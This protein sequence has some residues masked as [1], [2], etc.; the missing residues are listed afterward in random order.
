MKNLLKKLFSNSKDKKEAAVGRSTEEFASFE[1]ALRN[2][3]HLALKDQ[4]VQT[5]TALTRGQVVVNPDE[6]SKFQGI[7][8]AAY[9]KALKGEKVHVISLNEVVAK[10]R[11]EEIEG[12]INALN[13]TA[14]V[15]QQGQSNEERREAYKKN[16][17]FGTA[18]AFIHDY[19]KDQ[20]VLDIQERTQPERAFAL[21]E[22]G[23]LILLDQATRPVGIFGKDEKIIDSITLR[24]YFS[25]YR[26]ISAL[27]DFDG[28]DQPEFL[29]LYGMETFKTHE[30]KG[31]QSSG[32]TPSVRVYKT[33]EEK[34]RVILRELKNRVGSTEPLLVS[35]R[36]DEKGEL[37]IEHLQG[38]G[39]AFSS[40]LLKDRRD[41]ETF[42]T[43]AVE[44]QKIMLVVNPVS[45]GI[46]EF[47]PENIH[48]ISTERYML[49][50]NDEHLKR[51]AL[52]SG[53][54]GSIEYILSL[55][56]DLLDVFSEGELEQFKDSIVVENDQP[57]ENTK[58]EEMMDYVQQRMKEK[59]AYLRSY[60]QNF[61]S[62]IQRQREVIYSE[63][64]KVLTEE[65]I[66]EHILNLMED[67]IDE[68]IEKFTSNS[69]FPEEWDLEGLAS[70]L[71]N[72]FLPKDQL[73]FQDVENLTKKD[74]KANL[75]QKASKAYL[76]RKKALGKEP[77][78]LMQR[79]LLLKIIDSK[80]SEHLE[81]MEELRQDM[82]LRALG[83]QD[84]IRAFQVEGFELFENMTK[85]I[86]KD[87]MQ[88]LFA[89]E[90][91][92]K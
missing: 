59:N 79:V 44:N 40:L 55:G 82:N 23:D 13:F 60:V 64:K 52:N 90:E 35:L 25:N 31:N 72:S 24:S 84:P 69:V 15:L 87:L 38:T 56:D 34:R 73:V 77:F 30:E 6:E 1:E 86:P 14:A 45:R 33:L 21:V 46:D 10:R 32:E 41:E 26:E 11:M 2:V 71:S 66:K 81:S 4:A 68:E 62:V 36:N 5:A 85:T 67:A 7:A 3:K 63:R 17:I 76:E 75:I 80:W 91:E 65:D 58:V 61:E 43:E 37:L 48:I 12:I 50:R 70:A 88:A 92:D 16:V 9:L 57:I 27:V 89:T 19:L 49:K 54:K 39:I 28:G 47:L 74:L 53:E 83:R 18:G 20:K 8:L 78:D 29:D 42:V 22:K 51:M